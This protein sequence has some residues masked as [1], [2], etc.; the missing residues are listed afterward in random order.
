MR[1]T[2]TLFFVLVFQS[3]AIA[4]FNLDRIEKGDPAS[5]DFLSMMSELGWDVEIFPVPV[6]VAPG[7][8]E[9]QW[10]IRVLGTPFDRVGKTV[11]EA[12]GKIIREAI[13]SYG[14]CSGTILRGTS[15]GKPFSEHHS[16]RSLYS[17]R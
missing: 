15:Y 16:Q 12:V 2:A 14:L 9:T 6:P 17:T 11:E 5:E 1:V 3:F 13:F 7:V 4:Q 10:R 8:D